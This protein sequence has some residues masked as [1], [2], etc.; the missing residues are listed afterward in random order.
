MVAGSAAHEDLARW[1]VA[2]AP[3]LISSPFVVCEPSSA[4]RNSQ[5]ALRFAQG[6]SWHRFMLE[7]RIEA[8]I[9]A[10]TRDR[11]AWKDRQACQRSDDTMY[12]SPFATESNKA[13]IR[14]A[15]AARAYLT[16]RELDVLN[17]PVCR[18]A[19]YRQNPR[20]SAA[21]EKIMPQVVC[22]A[23]RRKRNQAQR[24]PP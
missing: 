20:T 18:C 6:G 3:G 19:H 1:Q 9:D 11:V 2:G 10:P 4:A 17:V 13:N 12:K 22:D 8:A 23:A 7:N 16:Q 5:T 15:S 21:W 24:T 14:E